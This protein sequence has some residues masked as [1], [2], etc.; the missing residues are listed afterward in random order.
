METRKPHAVLLASPGLGH[1]IPIIELGK[2]LVTHHGFIVTVFVVTVDTCARTQLLMKSSNSAGLLSIFHIPSVHIS[3]LLPTT[4]DIVTKIKVMMQ[5]SLPY[6]RSAISEMKTAP[7]ILV[8]DLFGTKAFLI[9]EE[10]NMLKYVFDTST[11]WFLAVTT[12][13][14]A[15]DS[16]AFD[17]HVNEEKPMSIPGCRPLPFKDTFEIFF[18]RSTPEYEQ[19]MAM[20]AEITTADGILVNTW[21]DLEST[22][23][24]ALR[25][26]KLLR[27]FVR[28]PVYPIGPVARSVRFPATGDL[29]SDWLD[30][31]PNKSVIYVSF[32]SGGTLPCKQMTELAWGLELS[33]Q[34]FLWVVR[35]PMENDPSGCFFTNFN[36]NEGGH[37]LHLD[38]LPV[39]FL[40]RTK[41]RG[42]VVP[43]WTSQPEILGHPSVGGFLS[44]CGWNSSLESLVNGVPMIAWPLFAEQKMNAAMLTELGVAVRSKE[45]A[46]S[47]VA[48]REEIGTMVR[49]LMEENEGETMRKRVE[50]LKRSAE[51]AVREGGSSYNTLS[52][53]TAEWEKKVFGTLNHLTIVPL[54][55]N[56]INHTF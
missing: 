17:E 53:L 50:K 25:D 20:A 28:A 6:L 22:T 39:G 38:F 10:F 37:Y 14:P 49:E 16:K 31:Q 48:S 21:E 44:H 3:T 54:L 12:Y 15:L 18:N 11:A 24:K 43:L 13:A 52:Q 32:G 33:H 29:V 40:T 42:L 30:R 47:G 9:A 27:P 55:E 56:W 36:D 23:L 5:E 45:L 1:L 19:F 26:K 46:A 4:S 41:G 35:P 7:A 8:V 34:R 2:R 51:E